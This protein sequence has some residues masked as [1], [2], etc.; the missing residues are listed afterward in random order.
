[1]K[2]NKQSLAAFISPHGFGHA[3]RTIAVLEA[4]RQKDPGIGIKL[5]TTV[6]QHI[7]TESL[8]NYTLTPVQ[9]DV[10]VVQHDA[11]H[12]DVEATLHALDKFL[13]FEP[14]LIDELAGQVR[15][16]RG[17]LC[18][19]SPLGIVVAEAAGIP[20]ILVEN[21]TWDWIY[22]QHP[23]L[24]KHTTMMADMFRRADT[25]IQTEPVCRKVQKGIPCP[26][27]FRQK[28]QDAPII[29]R[30]LKTGQRQIVLIS[31]G[32][33]GYTLKRLDLFRKY[34]DI[35]FVI[36]GAE[37]TGPLSDNCYSLSHSSTLYHPDLIAAADLV[38]C[39]AGY[40][41]VAECL[42]SGTSILCIDREG[43]A[44]T[45]VL[46]EFVKKRLDGTVIR[47]EQ[48][49]SGEWLTLLPSLLAAPKPQPAKQNGA[50][51]VAEILLG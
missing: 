48:L 31:M 39:K 2:T 42:Q 43:F 27:I 45:S 37:T 12:C 38:V 4:V 28:R 44:E 5:F 24:E 46:G 34:K 29:K 23:S 21:F 41:T 8:T 19:I 18:D 20:S 32:G 51:L 22:R 26:P 35:L 14:L 3:T 36:A 17:V 11:L 13:P 49:Q 33:I 10:G 7:F 6:H 50:E 9:T 25:R 16:C 40:S 15:G 47:E 1:M 30:Q